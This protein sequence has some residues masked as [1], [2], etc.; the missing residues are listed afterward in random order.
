MTMLLGPAVIIV[1]RRFWVWLSSSSSPPPL[2]TTPIFFVINDPP[3][4]LVGM[5]QYMYAR[6]DSSVDVSRNL[7]EG[8]L[9][10]VSHSWSSD[11]QCS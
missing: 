11:P 8:W 6:V 2:S 9:F 7:C 1:G 5:V 3:A 10:N 4:E